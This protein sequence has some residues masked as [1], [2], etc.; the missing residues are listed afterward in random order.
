MPCWIGSQRFI[1]N[2]KVEEDRYYRGYARKFASSVHAPLDQEYSRFIGAD[3][4]WLK[5]VPSQ[6]LRNGAVKWRQSYARFFKGL[7]D[8]RRSGRS[9]ASSRSG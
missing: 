3:T 4:A 8:G 6:I 9:T 7:A 1:Y 5:E 2:A